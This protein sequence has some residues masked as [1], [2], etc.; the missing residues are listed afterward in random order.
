MYSILYFIIALTIKFNEETNSE[1]KFNE[2]LEKFKVSNP[3]K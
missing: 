2:K 1:I 3:S